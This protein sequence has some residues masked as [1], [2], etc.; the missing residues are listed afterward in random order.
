MAKSYRTDGSAAYDVR[1]L[2]N[3]AQPLQKPR[4]LP[5]APAKQ[6]PQKATRAKIIVAPTAVLGTL[7]VAALLLVA[8][9]SYISLYEVQSEAADFA[10][11]LEALEEEQAFLQSK[12]EQSIDMQQIEQRAKELGL[13]QPV[14]SQTVY[15][16]VA[17]LN[18]AEVFVAP[19]EQNFIEKFF[20]ALCGAF[21]DALEYFS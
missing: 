16:S 3:T 2:Q 15:V 20:S 10:Q 5:D 11:E 6:Q 14:V 18:G 8:L 19:K 17:P 21:S 12:Y 9:F 1:R 4:R 7:A 13:R